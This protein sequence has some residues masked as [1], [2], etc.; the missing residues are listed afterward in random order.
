MTG[1]R[2]GGEMQQNRHQ[3]LIHAHAFETVGIREIVW[4]WSVSTACSV[5]IDFDLGTSACRLLIYISKGRPG[6]VFPHNRRYGIQREHLADTS[7]IMDFD[8]TRV[9]G[10][11]IEHSLDFRESACPAVHPSRLPHLYCSAQSSGVIP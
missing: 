5:F 8:C 9:V 2:E 6:F 1:G 7:K 10:A 3:T 11:V 4:R